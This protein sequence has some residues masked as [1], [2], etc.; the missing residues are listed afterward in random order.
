MRGADLNA[1]RVSVVTAAY[2]RAN[3]LRLT[4]ESLR[5]QTFAG[6]EM[7]VVGD[8]CTDDTEDVVRSFGDP[9][10]RFLNLPVNSGEQA[11][12]NN[13]GVRQARGE[14]IAFLN[15][16][17]LWA[18]EHLA[19]CLE[20]IERLRA[21]LVWTLTV[22][23]DAAGTPGLAGAC[24]AD[25]Y[26]PYVVAPASSWLLRRALADAVGPWRPARELFMPP[27]QEWLFRAWRKGHAL[28]PVKT[29]TVLAV[30]SGGR[31]NSYAGRDARDNETYAAQL[32][33]DPR[34]LLRLAAEIAAAQAAAV[35]DL[36]IARHVR[37]ALLNIAR[38][39]CVSAGVHP[40]S[41]HHAFKFRRRGGFL[42]SLRK[43]RGL[44]PLPRAGDLA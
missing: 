40:V 35:A 15:H 38:R 24:A 41:L 22:A 12:P 28:R 5:A 29:P 36:S 13:E 39:I 11:T 23:I 4:I 6:W 20:S 14:Y 37:R 31:R 16:D 3:V 32:A 33:N 9:R 30:H 43:T 34:L 18:P 21:D 19:T 42:D 1:P 26:E 25:R 2:N 44:P 7:I 17:D 10:I 8:A 27:S